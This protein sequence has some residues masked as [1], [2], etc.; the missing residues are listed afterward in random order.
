MAA[1]KII[2]SKPI[3]VDLTTAYGLIEVSGKDASTFLQGQLTCDIRQITALQGGFSAYCNAKGRILA[4]LRIFLYQENYY[5][6]LPKLLL[7]KVLAQLQQYAKFSKIS[8]KDVSLEWQRIGI[9]K[10][11]AI[12]S[13]LSPHSN[14][15]I[16][17]LIA[18][19]KHYPRV[20]LLGP[21]DLLSPLW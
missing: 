4:L 18:D 20:E 6:Q 16:Q 7:P 1:N 5:L 2:S 10:G 14:S 15:L 13:L 9:E 3:M 12:Q 17:L 8:L 21:P 11:E 19:T